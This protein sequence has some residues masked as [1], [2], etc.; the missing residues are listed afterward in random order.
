MAQTDNNKEQKNNYTFT[1]K[2]TD[3]PV[4]EVLEN[5][6][7]QTHTKNYVISNNVKGNI[8]F[9]LTNQTLENTLKIICRILPLTYTTIGEKEKTCLVD[10][11]TVPVAPLEA[12]K[13]DENLK[14]QEIPKTK[15]TEVISLIHLDPY[16][17]EKLFGPID[18]VKS[19]SRWR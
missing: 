3:R 1:Y 12:P 17:L 6:F 4:R 13:K 18:F 14:V 15:V 19:F 5:L 8:T 9:E 7:L 11:R 16:D 10:V 2:S